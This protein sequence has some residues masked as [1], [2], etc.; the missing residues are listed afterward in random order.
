MQT[1]NS[2]AIHVK[3]KMEPTFFGKVMFYFALA[4]AV[5]AFGTYVGFG[6]LPEIVASRGIIYGI[7]ALELI[8]VL[9]SRIWMRRRPMNYIL[10]SLFAFITGVA[11]APLL[12]VTIA[13]FG[14]L[15]IIKALAATALMFTATAILGSV[16]K[17]DFTGLRGWLFTFLIGMIIVSII[18]IFIPWS[19]TFEMIFSGFGVGLF[20]IYTA[21]DFQLM[22]RKNMPHEFAMDMALMLYLDIFNLFIYIL[23][24]MGS[25]SR[26]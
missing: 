8:L 13:E 21:V 11:I 19:N 7:F 10:F 25:I 1:Q 17:V 5:S 18:G 9:T 24:L 26:R 15:F 2:G 14:G 6:F 16:A 20:S 4:M 22:M 12:A 23:R 3:V